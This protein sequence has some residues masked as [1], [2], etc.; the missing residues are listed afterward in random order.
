M[1]KTT[2]LDNLVITSS[3]T[4][5]G[6]N[7]GYDSY[8]DLTKSIAA[9]TPWTSTTIDTDK[10]CISY[11]DKTED[12]KKYVEKLERHID[13]LEEDIDE[14][15]NQRKNLEEQIINLHAIIATKDTL[16]SDLQTRYDEL[17]N[18]VK[19]MQLYIEF[20]KS[21]YPPNEFYKLL[22]KLKSEDNEC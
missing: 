14:C 4:A 6:G 10:I 7:I 21:I 22:V 17:K 2:N 19:S 1:K 18:D 3:G 16:I 13:E 11:S 5:T 20:I 15:G 12:V 9:S 8:Y